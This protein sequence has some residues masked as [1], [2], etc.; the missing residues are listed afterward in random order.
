MDTQSTIHLVFIDKDRQADVQLRYP[1]VSFTD[2]ESQK[3]Q[4][5]PIRASDLVKI[6]KERQSDTLFNESAKHFTDCQ[7]ESQVDPK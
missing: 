4:D 6:I 5:R 2:L 3:S 1:R 7:L